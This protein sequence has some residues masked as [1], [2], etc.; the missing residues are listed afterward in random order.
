[1]KQTCISFILVIAFSFVAH[2][3]PLYPEAL[4]KEYTENPLGIDV[5]TSDGKAVWIDKSSL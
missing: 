2:A 5:Y 3:T 4:T 1:M